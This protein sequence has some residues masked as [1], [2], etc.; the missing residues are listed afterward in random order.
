MSNQ[1]LLKNG[2]IVISVALVIILVLIIS[3]Y[4]AQSLGFGNEEQTVVGYSDETVRARVIAVQEEGPAEV[5]GREQTYQV[6][7]IQILEGTYEQQ[8]LMLEMGKSQILSEEYLLKPDDVVLVNAAESLVTGKTAAYFVDFVRE[9]AIII[10][11]LIFS[12]VAFI[13]GGKTGLRSLL[14]SIVG[15]AIIAM[16]VIP[17]ILNGKN[18]LLV[19]II[20]SAMF[21]GFSLYIVY[22]WKGMTHV[23]VIGM[24]FSLF[25]TGAFSIFAVRLTRLTGFGDENMMFLV[26]QSENNIDMRGILI[27]GII[28]SSLGVLDD[29]V[30]GQSSAV[31]QLYETNPDLSVAELYKRA[32]VI[33]RDHVAAS[34]NTLILAYAGESLPMLL[35]FSLTNV[36][37]RLA[38]N[39]SYITE[40]IVQAL[41]GTT[42]LFL[43]IPIATFIATRWVKRDDKK[44]ASGGVS[45]S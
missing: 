41:A 44:D 9:K 20:G 6:L 8:R 36:D 32:M 30:V 35:L 4:L 21:L 22:G 45:Q 12:A 7:E 13:I 43:S 15:L 14:G 42:G 25:L 16:F 29:L 1:R 17:Q 33:G 34:V 28:I 23:A 18:P 26:Q 24:V 40:E 39:V 37:M 3:P 27:A 19:S 11:F 10:V 31:F 2:I 38:L 5:A